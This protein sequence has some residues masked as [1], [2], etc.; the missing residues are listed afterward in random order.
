MAAAEEAQ[1]LTAL[2]AAAAAGVVPPR[3]SGPTPPSQ[4][5]ALPMPTV[6]EDEEL[7]LEGFRAVTMLRS[8]REFDCPLGRRFRSRPKA[9]LEVSFIAWLA[10]IHQ[11]SPI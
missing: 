6:L 4:P 8:G 2:T 3:A 1:P 11:K 5:P 10:R 9:L 7:L